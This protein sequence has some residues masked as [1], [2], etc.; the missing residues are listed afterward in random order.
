KGKPRLSGTGAAPRRR[1]GETHRA[2][3]EL[4]LKLADIAGRTHPGLPPLVGRRVIEVDALA[5]AALQARPVFHE[6]AAVFEPLN[7]VL[8]DRVA[9]RVFDLPTAD[10]EIELLVFRQ[11]FAGTRQ[12]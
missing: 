4:A 1:A 8:A 9:L 11:R 12:P 7:D 5:G 6:D 2:V 3:F 10:P